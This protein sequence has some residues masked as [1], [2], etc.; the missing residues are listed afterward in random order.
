M[1]KQSLGKYGEDLVCTHL[2]KNGFTIAER[3]F[4]FRYGEIDIIAQKDG[5]TAFVEVKTRQ[6]DAFGSPAEAVGARKQKSILLAAQQYISL[7]GKPDEN[8]TFD[9]AEVLIREGVPAINYIQNA[10][11]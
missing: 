8:Y 7:K 9:V 4:R 1:D 2:K 6:S 3:N 5:L 11:C 10:F